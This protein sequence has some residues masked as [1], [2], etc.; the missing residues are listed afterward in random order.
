[1]WPLDARALDILRTS[2][3]VTARCT[4]YASAG[5]VALGDIP[6]SGGAVTFDAKS[7]VRRSASI[8][9]ADPA[10][11]PAFPTDPLSPVG[12]ELLIEYGVLVPGVA[13]PFWVPLIRGPIQKVAGDLSGA[14][15]LTVEVMDRSKSVADNRPVNPFQTNP[16]ATCVQAITELITES[17]NATVVDLTGS[18]QPCPVLDID[19]DRWGEGV[20][21]LSDAIGAE[22]YCDRDGTFVIRPQPQIEDY[23][24]W[25]VDA[26]KTGVLITA[27][28]ELSRQQVYNAVVARGE[29]TDGTPPVWGIKVDDDPSSPTAWGGSFG[30][31]P[32]FYTSPLLGEVIQCETTAA[33]L[34]ARVKGY[35]A[36]VEVETVVNPALDP[37]DVILVTLEDRSTQRH[38]IDG[39]PVP[40]S[41]TESQKLTTRTTS[42]LP[43][44]S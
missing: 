2:H 29:R 3:T 22:T 24:V 27:R 33:A 17:V 10:L 7:Q 26:G 38:I 31:R 11:W 34:L 9:V 15:P 44:E 30:K 13:L 16:A 32:R 41:P 35:V 40:L 21:R 42:E 37:G 1:M 8:T 12:P 28:R 23:P 4:A 5:G 6:I 39:M 36:N 18:T 20:E 25:E 43:P 19:K 14:E